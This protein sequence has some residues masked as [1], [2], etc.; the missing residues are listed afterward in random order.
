MTLLQFLQVFKEL[1]TYRG[2]LKK[3]AIPIV[4]GEYNESLEPAEG[5][6]CQ[7]QQQLYDLV[8]NNVQKLIKRGHYYT[9]GRDKN[10]SLF[11]HL[12]S[13]CQHLPQGR[14]NNLSHPCI[15]KLCVKFYYEN[16]NGLARKCRD[17]F[18]HEVPERA[19]ALIITVVCSTPL[20]KLCLIFFVTDSQLPRRMEIWFSYTNSV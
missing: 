4:L 13:Y 12:C 5:L 6:D 2:T 15:G 11:M 8:A 20:K 19:V 16:S 17:D 3:M 1:S 10:V 9:D 18:K 7:N 14:T